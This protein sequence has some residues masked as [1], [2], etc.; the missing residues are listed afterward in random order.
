MELFYIWVVISILSVII[1]I[2]IGLLILLKFMGSN[3][4]QSLFKSFSGEV[5][6]AEPEKFLMRRRANDDAPLIIF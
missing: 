6:L 4:G 1:V 5:E 3:S 2:L